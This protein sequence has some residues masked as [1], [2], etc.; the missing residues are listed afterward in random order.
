MLHGLGVRVHDVGDPKPCI[1]VSQN[2]GYCCRYVLGGPYTR[3][4]HIWGLSEL[5]GFPSFWAIP[6]IS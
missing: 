2:Q 4:S 3:D 1:G 6:Y 5:W